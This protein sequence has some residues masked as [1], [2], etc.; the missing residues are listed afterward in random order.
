[1][2]Q[3]VKSQCPMKR[4][5]PEFFKAH[6]TFISSSILMASRRLQTRL[7]KPDML[8][9][10]SCR[11]RPAQLVQIGISWWPS[12]REFPEFFKT[13][14][15]FICRWIFKVSRTLKLETASFA[16]HHCKSL[17]AVDELDKVL[18][19]SW[20][21]RF[22]KDW[23]NSKSNSQRMIWMNILDNWAVLFA[24]IHNKE[25]ILDI[26]LRV[27]VF[28]K[29]F[30]PSWSI[31]KICFLYIW[32]KKDSLNFAFKILQWMMRSDITCNQ[33]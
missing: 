12:C 20:T 10:G 8:S 5:F 7:T 19:L 2:V 13:H 33:Q 23:K 31:C 1:M 17:F 15:T 4:E 26:M 29:V 30:E 3:I 6:P 28:N 21:E 18:S 9:G 32:R 16:S 11:R 24:A 27:P 25:R 22:K 14:P